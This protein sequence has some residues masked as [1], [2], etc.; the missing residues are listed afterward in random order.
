MLGV[1][2][3]SP[4][5]FFAPYPPYWGDASHPFDS[6]LRHLEQF[7]ENVP[8]MRRGRESLHLKIFQRASGAT[9]LVRP[10]FFSGVF[11]AVCQQLEDLALEPRVDKNIPSRGSEVVQKTLV[12]SELHEKKQIIQHHRSSSQVAWMWRYAAEQLHLGLHRSFSV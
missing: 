3:Q 5:G 7:V 11:Q 6:Q 8:D 4:V 9:S 2:P 10:P 12:L 1:G